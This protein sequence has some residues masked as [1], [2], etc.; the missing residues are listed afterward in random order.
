MKGP[1]LIA[2]LVV[3]ALAACGGSHR[4]ATFVTN[5]SPVPSSPTASSPSSGYPVVLAI[6]RNA[7]AG[8]NLGDG[9]SLLS[10]TR[11]AIVTAGSGSCP[12]VPDKLVVENPDTIR[13]YLT[14]GTYGP[15]GNSH[16]MRLVT[17][18]SRHTICTA[19]LTTT[20]MVIAINPSQIN[21]HH[22][23]AVY[24]YYYKTKNPIVRYAQPL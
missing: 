20:P 12:A 2:S 14:M 11:L 6:G 3:L 4:S 8:V 24:L 23:L 17:H 5:V 13:L 9:A 15:I 21:V 1:L 18:V 19:D 16:Q 10:P 22:R 7:L